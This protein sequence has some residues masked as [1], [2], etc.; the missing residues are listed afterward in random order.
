MI[1]HIHIYFHDH[2]KIT[3]CNTNA[4]Q[5]HIQTGNIYY[6]VI[7][8]YKKMYYTILSKLLQYSKKYILRPI[9]VIEQII[10]IY[11]K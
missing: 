2:Q 7:H 11:H 3:T 6:N 9:K 10:F 8:T 1:K 4:Y 5:F